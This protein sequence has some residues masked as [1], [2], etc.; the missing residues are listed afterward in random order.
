MSMSIERRQFKIE[1]E[2]FHI[3]ARTQHTTRRSPCF[4]TEY[5]MHRR[6]LLRPMIENQQD[7]KHNGWRGVVDYANVDKLP[8]SRNKHT[9]IRQLQLQDLSPASSEGTFKLLQRV[10]RHDTSFFRINLFCGDIFQHSLHIIF[11]IMAISI[12]ESM[13]GRTTYNVRTY[14][15]PSTAWLQFV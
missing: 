14:E 8:L 5:T 2:A 4:M 15:L 3:V 1:A 9:N 12:D 6:A 13:Y 11:P 7:S 10:F